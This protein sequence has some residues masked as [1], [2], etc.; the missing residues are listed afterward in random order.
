MSFVRGADFRLY[1]NTTPLTDALV[2]TAVAAFTEPD[3]EA[4]FVES[5]TPNLQKDEIEFAVRKA[6]PDSPR[7]EKLYE[8]GP[9]ADSFEVALVYTKGAS[10]FYD[11]AYASYADGTEI[12][13]ADTDDAID[14]VGAKG[15]TGNFKC[16][17]VSREEPIGDM[18]RVTLT[19]RP[20]SFINRKF[21]TPGP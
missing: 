9:F 8:A 10:T 21:V 11:A 15:Y 18:A 19:F 6:T 17:N 16:L 7:G 20:S 4:G 3:D 5:V 12:A 13:M 1:F 2:A 14:V